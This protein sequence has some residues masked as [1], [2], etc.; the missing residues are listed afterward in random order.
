MFKYD[1]YPGYEENP[2]ANSGLD[3]ALIKCKGKIDTSQ[4]LICGIAPVSNERSNELQSAYILG[5]PAEKK[6]QLWGMD[7]CTTVCDDVNLDTSIF[8]CFKIR[9]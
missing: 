5:F 4:M 9:K 3:L 8:V 7:C 6:G 1:I 2:K